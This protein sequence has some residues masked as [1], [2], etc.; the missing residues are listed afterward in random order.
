MKLSQNRLKIE[1]IRR[2]YNTP[3]FSPIK[4]GE[5]GQK[6]VENG[7]NLRKLVANNKNWRK[8][9]PLFTQSG[10]SLANLKKKTA[11]TC[12]KWQKTEENRPEVECWLI[13]AHKNWRK[14]EK[15]GC[16]R[17]KS[18]RKMQKLVFI[19]KNWQKIERTSYFSF[20]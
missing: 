15:S 20:F 11:K 8:V 5:N 13:L 14:W 1:K 2:K 12:L 17:T 19:D 7:K 9:T 18:C 3:S 16:R 4:T 6:A 10:G